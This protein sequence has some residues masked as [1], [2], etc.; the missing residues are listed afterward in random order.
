MKV[1]YKCLPIPTLK[2]LMKK[3]LVVLQLK[4]IC[5]WTGEENRLLYQQ[6]I[7]YGNRIITK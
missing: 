4:I 2:Y 1:T 5:R 3:C 6:N 7:W